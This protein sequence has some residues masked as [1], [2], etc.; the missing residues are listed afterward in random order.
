MY[1]KSQGGFRKLTEIDVASARNSNRPLSDKVVFDKIW[2]QY[3]K[4]RT[5]VTM[6]G[7]WAV[8]RPHHGNFVMVSSQLAA[9]VPGL[10]I[11]AMQF[12]TDIM[13][14]VAVMPEG[15]PVPPLEEVESGRYEFDNKI[16]GPPIP[17]HS[18]IHFLTKETPAHTEAI[19]TKRFPQKLKDS[20]FYGAKPLDKEW[21]IEIVETRNWLLLCI[22]QLSGLLLS[23]A[24]AAV[25]AVVTGDRASGIA[26]GSW[27]SAV[28]GLVVAILFFRWA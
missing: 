18:F 2:Q 8:H 1:W 23:G 9:H 25:Y 11:D 5:V 16:A 19:W 27:C 13:P 26:I 14:K 4:D 21:G 10:L 15:P 20:V 3:S 6:F 17:P 28:Q 24:L 12:L 7:K 22:L